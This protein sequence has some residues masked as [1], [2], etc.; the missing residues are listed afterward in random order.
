MYKYKSSTKLLTIT[1]ILALIVSLIPQSIQAQNPK[2]ERE[3][4]DFSNDRVLPNGIPKKLEEKML[5][6]GWIKRA[7]KKDVYAHV[8]F[9]NKKGNLYYVDGWVKAGT[10]V[11]VSGVFDGF[12]MVGG[13]GNVMLRH[14]KT[15]KDSK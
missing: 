2:K 8:Q 10:V 5:S 12:E 7:L 13:C 4:L 15:I 14:R 9:R 6:K 11:F 1:V 3:Y